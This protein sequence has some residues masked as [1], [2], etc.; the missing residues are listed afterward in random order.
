MDSEASEKKAKVLAYSPG[1]HPIL[2]AELSLGGELRTLYYETGYDPERT[3][4]VN[5]DWLQENA[6]GRHDFVRLDPPRE[7]PLSALKDYV[8][9]ELL[10]EL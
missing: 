5:Q 9:W 3:K 4:P 7:V 8:R 6:I 2:V 10:K 1:R